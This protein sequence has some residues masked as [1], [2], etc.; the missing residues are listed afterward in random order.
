[1]AC[2]FAFATYRSELNLTFTFLSSIHRH[3]DT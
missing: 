1:M 3:V 2:D